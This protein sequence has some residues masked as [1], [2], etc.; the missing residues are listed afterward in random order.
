[1]KSLNTLK[2]L[3]YLLLLLVVFN[4]GKLDHEH[5][6]GEITFEHIQNSDEMESTPEEIEIGI[7][8]HLYIVDTETMKTKKIY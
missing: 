3:F 5:K 8:G 4:L 2:Y 7:N 6:H 1:M